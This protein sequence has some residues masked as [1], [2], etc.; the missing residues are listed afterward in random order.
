MFERTV[1]NKTR[2][3]AGAGSGLIGGLVFGMMMAKM[4][5]LPMIGSPTAAAG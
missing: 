5:M 2:L 4:G 1:F 3:L